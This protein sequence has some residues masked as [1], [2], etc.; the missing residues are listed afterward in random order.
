MEIHFFITIHHHLSHSRLKNVFEPLR[1]FKITG[2]S[3]C[4]ELHP[5]DFLVPTTSIF[6]KSM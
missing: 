1:P 3:A 6:A 2:M 5:L 4:L